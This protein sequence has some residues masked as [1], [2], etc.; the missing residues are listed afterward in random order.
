MKIDANLVEEVAFISR[1]EL[2]QA[3]KESFPRQLSQV[4]QYVERLCEVDTEGVEPTIHVI[5]TENVFRED[6]VRPSLPQK[7]AL[8]NAPDKE[9][10]YF[11]VPR[12][13]E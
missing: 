12:I 3:E 5:P 11:K 10:G 1:L 13:V 8:R 6:K 4:F 9:D 7:E 2:S